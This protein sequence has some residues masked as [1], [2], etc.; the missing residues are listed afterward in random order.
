MHDPSVVTGGLV[1]DRN[2]PP[3]HNIAAS[4]AA[5]GA[6]TSAAAAVL[7]HAINWRE[8]VVQ[9]G[10]RTWFVQAARLLV[11]RTCPACRL[12]LLG[13]SSREPLSSRVETAFFITTL[14]SKPESKIQHPLYD[15]NQILYN[16]QDFIR[17]SR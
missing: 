17:I 12:P 7:F 9:H 2:L 15:Y 16:Q 10:A 8:S 4:A 1:A 14:A 6:V 11:G 13:K 3:T 5:S